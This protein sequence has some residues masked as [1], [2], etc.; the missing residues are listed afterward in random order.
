MERLEGRHVIPH[1]PHL[2][3]GEAG[4]DGPRFPSACIH[5]DNIVVVPGHTNNRINMINQ[6]NL[7]S[8]CY[9]YIICV[10]V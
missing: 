4:G 2:C 1:L 7:R 6:G 5:A 8:L 3:S 9:A 10:R